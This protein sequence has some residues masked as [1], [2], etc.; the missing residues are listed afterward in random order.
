MTNDYVLIS[1]PKGT[2]DSALL[3]LDV[4]QAYEFCAARKNSLSSRVASLNRQYFPNRW[5]T[6]LD[7][8]HFKVYVIREA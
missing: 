8:P 4:G 7:R 1:T 6:Q 5:R 2:I 3:A